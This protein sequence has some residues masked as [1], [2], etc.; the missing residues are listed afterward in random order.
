MKLEGPAMLAWGSLTGCL[1]AMMMIMMMVAGVS[2]A[3]AVSAPDHITL[4]MAIDLRREVSSEGTV[5][6]ARG[7]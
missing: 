1:W 6:V 4:Q 7:G 5:G 2:A 3:G